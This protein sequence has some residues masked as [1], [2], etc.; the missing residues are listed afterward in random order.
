MIDLMLSLTACLNCD[1]QMIE[2]IGYDPRITS[3][4]EEMPPPPPHTLSEL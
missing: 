1:F 2:M 3:V 4:G